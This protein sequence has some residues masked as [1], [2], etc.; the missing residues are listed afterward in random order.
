M[1]WFGGCYIYDQY[2]YVW[3]NIHDTELHTAPL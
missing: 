1:K 3:T 2:P